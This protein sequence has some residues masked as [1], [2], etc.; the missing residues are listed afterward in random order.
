[1][2]R[3]QS[4]DY[5]PLLLL[6]NSDSF[7]FSMEEESHETHWQ[8][9]AEKENQCKDHI[10][11]IIVL[12]CKSMIRYSIPAITEGGWLAVRLAKNHHQ[13][14]HGPQYIKCADQ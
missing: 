1:M 13:V 4:Y 3:T 14:V 12:F 7:F 2:L 5:L 10:F 9:L 8:E 11:H 6:L